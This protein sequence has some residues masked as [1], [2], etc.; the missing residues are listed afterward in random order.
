MKKNKDKN[1]END[2]IK[3]NNNENIYQEEDKV[4]EEQ[5]IETPDDIEPVDPMEV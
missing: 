5:F 1:K 2:I 3:R 4:G